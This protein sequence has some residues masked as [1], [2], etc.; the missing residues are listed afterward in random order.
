MLWN[1]QIYLFQKLASS[2][3]SW[4]TFSFKLNTYQVSSSLSQQRKCKKQN[5]STALFRPAFSWSINFC[6]WVLCLLSLP[7]QGIYF[8]LSG[9]STISGSSCL[10]Y[11]GVLLA[12][13]FLVCFIFFLLMAL[14]LTVIT[15]EGSMCGLC[16]GDFLNYSLWGDFRLTSTMIH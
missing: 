1:T 14:F 8:T 13:D 12:V 7:C 5:Q 16:W 9:S 2:A 11:L 15:S 3:I 4:F 6:P 10:F